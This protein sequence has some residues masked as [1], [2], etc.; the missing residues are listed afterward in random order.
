MPDTT[1]TFRV[2]QELKNA[3][4]EAERA[5]DRPGSQRNS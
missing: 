2:D 1:F 3:F 5:N 4:T